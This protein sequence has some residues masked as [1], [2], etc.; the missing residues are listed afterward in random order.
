MVTIYLANVNNPWVGLFLGVGGA[1]GKLSQRAC[2][3]FLPSKIEVAAAGE[4]A[5]RSSGSTSW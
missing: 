1:L 3:P 5:M 4:K 2:N